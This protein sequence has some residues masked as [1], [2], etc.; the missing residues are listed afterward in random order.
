ME[1]FVEY[2][3][4]VGDKEGN[5]LVGEAVVG[6]PVEGLIVGTLV[7]IFVGEKVR[8][9]ELVGFKVGDAEG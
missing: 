3:I 1:R 9:A 5:P 2:I 7:G 4:T 6:D 8:V